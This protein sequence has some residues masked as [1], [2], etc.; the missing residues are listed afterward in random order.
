M[1]PPPWFEEYC[2]RK[3]IK[4][5]RRTIYRNN[6]KLV[7]Q[8]LPIISVSNM[9]SLFPKLKNYKNDILKRE[10]G[11]SLLSEVWEKKGKKKQ[12]LEIEKMLQMDGLKYVST[13]RPSSKRGGGCAIVA[14]LSMFTLEKID[15]T[16]PK[17]VEVTYGLLRTK[18]S[19]AKFKEIIAVAFYSPPKSRKKMQLLDHIIATCHVLLTKYP[20]AVLVI[21][22]DRNEMSITPLLDSIPKLRQINTKNTCNGKV[23]DV[24]LINIPEHYPPPCIVPPVPADN[25][26]KGCPSD[27]STV[28]A[29]PLSK[30]GMETSINEYTTKT[31]RPLPES[32]KVEFGQWIMHE[33]WDCIQPDD[34][35]DVQVEVLQNL[36]TEKL[37]L[38]F[39]TKTVRITQKDKCYI[40]ADI[41]KLDR[42]V[43]REYRKHG[44]SQ[45]YLKLLEKYDL[46]M[47]KAAADHLE[48][49]VR[50]LKESDPGKAYST[51]KKMGAQP[52]D[53]LD[54]GSFSLISHLEKN[55]TNKESVEQIADHFSKISQEYPPININS[56]P[57][58]VQL[59]LSSRLDEMNIPILD[60]LDVYR[61][62]KKTKKPKAGVPGDLPRAL[63]QEFAPELATPLEKIY[64]NITRT[65]KWPT[66]WKVEYGIPLKKV[67]NPI[68]EDGLRI[69]SLTAF[70]SKVYEKIVMEWLMEYVGPHIDWGQYGGQKG[71]SV[72][73]YLIDF[74][75]FVMYNHDLKNMHA[76]LAVAIDFSKAFNRQ[77]HNILV[78]LLSDLGVP[79]W[80]LQIVIG[81]LENRVLQVSFKNEE[82]RRKKLPGGG[83]QGTILGMFLFLI[84]INAAGFRNNLKNIGKFIT[85][86]FNRRVPMPR[87]HLKYIDDMTIAEALNLK[88]CLAAN[89]DPNPPRPLEYHQRT[90]HVLPEGQSAVQTMLTDL[91]EYTELNE[92]KLNYEKTKVILFNKSRKYDFLPQ[93]QLE[94]GVNLEVV[95]EIKLLG[96]TV[97]SD[98]SWSSHCQNMCAKGFSRLWM[99]RRLQPLGA[100]RAELVEVYQTQIRCVLEFAVA[101][102]NAGLTKQ[103]SNQIER[104]QKTAFAIILGVDYAS[105]ANALSV[106]NMKTL[107]DRRH[108]LS[109]KFA[110]KSLKHE[111]YSSWFCS[112]D[113]TSNTRSTKPDLKNVEALKRRFEKSPLYYL[114][115]LLNEHG[116]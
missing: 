112:N 5:V 43:K 90:G 24:L 103:Q 82:S 88:K 14:D 70:N 92:M 96:V 4:P 31:C 93:C 63:I 62:I 51:L 40:N 21:G 81:F 114:T 102:W 41:K 23:L 17:S 3:Y 15:V 38:I 13:P 7:G 73:H 111:K 48:K 42:L 71:N 98:L 97:R 27:H 25:P 74:I 65:G 53:M 80:L 29:T 100:N 19:D 26:A 76:V 44:K 45:K 60:E 9:R 99:L 37:N 78:T 50:S 104:V 10:I 116:K 35:T 6:K 59:K 77:N 34:P 108:D 94:Q 107:S 67:A 56:L 91:R 46:K 61:K 79:G 87:I 95:E 36:M 39:P 84:L 11:L 105:Y 113:V 64:N 86:P 72:T 75:N 109:L 33:N 30:P 49:N 89:P 110:Q 85:R 22:G 54:D 8:S 55:L 83:P 47:K 16:I 20:Q 68:D 1:T 32:G 101:A 69:I 58:Q 66:D 12:K 28:V 18:N 106:L 115:K 52:G 57:E 2:Q